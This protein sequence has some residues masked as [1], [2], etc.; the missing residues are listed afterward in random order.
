MYN[1]NQ[2]ITKFLLFFVHILSIYSLLIFFNNA[3]LF[4]Q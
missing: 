2:E 4:Q 3:L 1:N